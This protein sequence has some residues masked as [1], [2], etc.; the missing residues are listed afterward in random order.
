MKVKSLAMTDVISDVMET[1]AMMSVEPV[2]RF[3][4]FVPDFIGHIDFEGPMRG[5][6]FIGCK[7]DFA[8]ALAENLLGL[9][10]SELD[11]HHKWDAVGE[12]LNVICGNLVTEIFDSQKSF[13]LSVPQ[14]SVIDTDMENV[15]NE[16][17]QGYNDAEC[18]RFIIDGFPVQFLLKTND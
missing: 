18:A 9:E 6:L 15:G 11:E 2:E 16:Q 14:V 12:L 5:R 13:T 1:L 10:S 3:D 8:T 4:D 7:A 17:Y